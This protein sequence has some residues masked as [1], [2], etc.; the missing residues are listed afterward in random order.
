[1][2]STS[3]GG[4]FGSLMRQ[5]VLVL[6]I[7]LAAGFGL[8]GCSGGGE[9]ETAGARDAA[10]FFL[11]AWE[12]ADWQ[13]LQGLVGGASAAAQAHERA[14]E[15]LG[16]E[17][18]SFELTRLEAG[19]G[20]ATAHFT[21]RMRVRG[22]GVWAYR[23]A[24]RLRWEDGRWVVAWRPSTIHPALRPGVR[25]ATIRSWPKRAPILAHDGRPLVAEREVIEL[26]VEPRRIE[27]RRKLLRALERLLGADPEQ[28]RADLD[29]PGVQPDWFIPVSLLRPERYEELKP[30]LYPVPGTVF[31]RSTARL[32][33]SDEFALHTLGRVGEIT[34]ELLEQHGHP[35]VV[36]DVVGLSGL[37]FALER[38]LTGRPSGRVELVDE[39]GEVVRVLHHFSGK[40]PQLVRTT[41]DL[42]AQTA[43]ERALAGIRRPAALVAV[44][45]ATGE[46]RA[47]ASR[48]LGE[49]NRA[50]AGH[51]PPGSTFKVVTTAALLAHGVAAG[52]TVACPDEA[53]LG[54]RTFGNA[55]GT[56][57]GPTSFADAFAVSCNT[58]FVQLAE[59]LPDGSLEQAARRF[60]FGA[61]YQLPLAVAGGRFPRPANRGEELEAAIGQGRVEAS[62]VHMANVAAAVASGRWRPP[63]LL[64]GTQSAT[65]RL[66]SPAVAAT[67]RELMRLVVVA[68]TGQAAAVAGTEVYGKTGTAEFGAGDPPNAHAWFI[69]F[70]DGLAFAVLVE[71]GGSGSRVAAP[72]AA[73]FLEPLGST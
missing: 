9:D 1:L 31:R 13:A 10:G 32:P 47:V 14:F 65:G 50:L 20:S 56:P 54:G 49:F 62:P 12:R 17:R 38:R 3:V 51:Y 61:R 67:L 35:Y 6:F 2:A 68:G 45:S 66:L 21:A 44:D 63:R 43:A 37:E 36:G 59:T 8:A 24:L 73:R 52:D 72:I 70:R 15:D 4:S 60:G 48:P 11:A 46:L 22:L 18:A 34:A 71:G 53:E 23:G 28:V 25:F 58:A 57:V 69:G 64:A 55:Q 39:N 19:D 29:R 16:V 5:A 33:P 40:Q 7:V 30:E 26:G 41:L 42:D 27:S